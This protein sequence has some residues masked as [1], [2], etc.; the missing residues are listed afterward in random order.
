[1]GGID[2]FDLRVVPC[3]G[4]GLGCVG[5]DLAGLADL[6]DVLL[7]GLALVLVLEPER[8]VLHDLLLLGQVRLRRRLLRRHPS[9]S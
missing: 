7:D 6:L 1:V 5:L 3:L 4:G 2:S 8:L 9:S